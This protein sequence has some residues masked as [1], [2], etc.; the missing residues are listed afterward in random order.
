[1]GHLKINYKRNQ[2]QRTDWQLSEG[3]EFARLGGE[4]E[5]IKQKDKRIKGITVQMGDK[6]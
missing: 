6:K 1:M 4:S 3:R 2:I 5:K